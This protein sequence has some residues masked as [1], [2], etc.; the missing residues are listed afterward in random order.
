MS[1]NLRYVPDKKLKAA[2]IVK[3]SLIL[4]KLIDWLMDLNNNWRKTVKQLHFSSHIYNVKLKQLKIKV[5][6][7]QTRTLFH[8]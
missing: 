7:N 1:N 3:I 4:N 5:K 6:L 8:K 2:V